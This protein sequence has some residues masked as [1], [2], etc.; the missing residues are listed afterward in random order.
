MSDD[1]KIIEKVG[2]VTKGGGQNPLANGLDIPDRIPP[3]KDKFDQALLRVDPSQLPLKVEGSRNGLIDEVRA[4]GRQVDNVDRV[5]PTQLAEQSKGVIKQI[6]DIKQK[7]ADPSLEIKGDYKRILR[8]KLEHINDNLKVALNRAGIK[9]EEP[10]EAVKF[11]K[12]PVTGF[13]DLL[14][15][16]QQQLLSLGGEVGKMGSANISP[17]NLLA[18]QVKVNYIQQELEFFT[19]LLNKALESAKTIMNVQV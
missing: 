16:G 18:V 2:K 7:L 9:Y 10:T 14:T 8:N 4:I 3:D 6:E 5:G 11:S 13:I 12:T 15:H 1:E 17:S 19:S